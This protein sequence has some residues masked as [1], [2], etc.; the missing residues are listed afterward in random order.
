MLHFLRNGALIVAATLPL[1]GSPPLAHGVPPGY[2]ESVA[3]SG[4]AQRGNHVPVKVR[5]AG[6]AMQKQDCLTVTGA[7]VDVMHANTVNVGIVRLEIIVGQIVETPVRGSEA[8]SHPVSF[9][10]SKS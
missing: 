6:F 8:G 4:L 2:Q 9:F 10:D 5:P 7:F 3:V 1:W